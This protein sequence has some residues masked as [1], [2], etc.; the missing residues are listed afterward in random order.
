MVTRMIDD[1]GDWDDLIVTVAGV[2]GLPWWL[3]KEEKSLEGRG[4][5]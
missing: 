2:S 3:Y 4:G 1:Y 5:R